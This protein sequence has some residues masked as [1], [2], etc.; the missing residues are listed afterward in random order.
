MKTESSE[1]VSIASRI[2]ILAVEKYMTIAEIERKAKIGNGTIKR[3]DKSYPSAEKLYRVSSILGVSM[4]FLITGECISSDMTNESSLQEVATII[5]SWA[6]RN[7]KPNEHISIT[8][9][10]VRVTTEEILINIA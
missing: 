6:K 4:E 8:K 7:L 3:W 10:N 1:A 2:Q 5:H 9:N